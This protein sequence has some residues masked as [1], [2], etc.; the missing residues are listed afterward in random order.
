MLS[1]PRCLEGNVHSTQPKIVESRV[2]DNADNQIA[3]TPS[4]WLGLTIYD[5]STG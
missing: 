2:F 3:F 1:S 4:Q 5:L